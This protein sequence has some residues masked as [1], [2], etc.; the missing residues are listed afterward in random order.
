M[1]NVD[2]DWLIRLRADASTFARCAMADKTADRLVDGLETPKLQCPMPNEFTRCG[3]R[4]CPTLRAGS[5]KGKNPP[6]PAFWW[7][8]RVPNV[9]SGAQDSKAQIQVYKWIGFVA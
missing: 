9:Q 7:G 8:A 6:L 5:S 3:G 1:K 4:L 2:G